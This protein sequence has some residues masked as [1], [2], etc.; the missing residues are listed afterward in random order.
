MS[1]VERA[2]A[3]S[4]T[5]ARRCGAGAQTARGDDHVQGG[6]SHEEDVRP[7]RFD[8]RPSTFDIRAA[9]LSERID[10]HATLVSR[11]ESPPCLTTGA[12]S[13]AAS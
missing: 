6:A 11:T 1:N 8:I 4:T 5:G 7:L 12:L 13:A 3:R 10:E 2:G 9:G